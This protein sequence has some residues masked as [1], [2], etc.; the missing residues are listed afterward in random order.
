M[1]A[2]LSIIG[3]FGHGRILGRVVM[4]VKWAKTEISAGHLALVLALLSVSVH[5]MWCMPKKPV[6]ISRRQW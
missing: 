6:F 2:H 4:K 5:F 3:K 1:I